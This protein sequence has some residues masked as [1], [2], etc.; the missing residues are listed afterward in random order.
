M[1][2]DD[3]LSRAVRKSR[4]PENLRFQT[5]LA[6]RGTLLSRRTSSGFGRANEQW[7]SAISVGKRLCNMTDRII[8]RLTLGA[9]VG[10][11]ERD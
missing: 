5:T 3:C 1:S 6:P 11:I 9:F 10:S 8:Y 7:L 4:E 2:E